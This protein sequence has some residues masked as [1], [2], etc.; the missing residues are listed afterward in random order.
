MFGKGYFVTGFEANEFSK[1]QSGNKVIEVE[2]RDGKTIVRTYKIHH[3]LLSPIG[4]RTHKTKKVVSD[5]RAKAYV[6]D[7]KT[8]FLKLK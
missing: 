4:I 3:S 2:K 7:L 1:Y 5:S 8:T 6:E